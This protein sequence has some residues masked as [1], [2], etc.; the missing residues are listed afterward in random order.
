MEKRCKKCV[1]FVC[2]HF[3]CPKIFRFFLSG[4]DGNSETKTF[5]GTGK[6]MLSNCLILSNM[7]VECSHFDL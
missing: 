5:G 6:K 7:N 2:H 4:R 3:I 1:S